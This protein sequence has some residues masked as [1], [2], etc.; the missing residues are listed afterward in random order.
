MKYLSTCFVMALALTGCSNGGSS[1]DG[2]NNSPGPNAPLSPINYAGKSD[3]ATLTPESAGAFFRYL[4]SD[5][6]TTAIAN[7][8]TLAR[9]LNSPMSTPLVLSANAIR[10]TI[11]QSLPRTKSQARAINVADSLPCPQ[12]GEMSIAGSVDEATGTG[13]VVLTYH[14][15][16]ANNEHLNG[17]MHLLFQPAAADSLWKE[18]TDVTIAGLTIVN[19]SG[20]ISVAGH[21][22]ILDNNSCASATTENILVRDDQTLDVIR[23]E[24]LVTAE[25]ICRI[26]GQ[27]SMTTYQGRIY[28]SSFGFVDVSTVPNANPNADLLLSGATLILIGA[29]G[30]SV[31]VSPATPTAMPTTA[32]WNVEFDAATN[33]PLK[34]FTLSN[35]SVVKGALY[36]LGDNDQDGLLNAWERIYGLDPNNIADA[37]QDQDGDGFSNLLEARYATSPVSATEFPATRDLRVNLQGSPKWVAPPAKETLWFDFSALDNASVFS[38][39]QDASIAFTITKS[40][41]VAWSYY[42]ECVLDEN[43]TSRLFCSSTAGYGSVEITAPDTAGEDFWVQVSLTSAILDPDLNNNVTTLKATS[44]DR[45]SDMHAYIRVASPVAVGATGQLYVY[46]NVSANSDTALD[47]IV[48][49]ALPNGVVFDGLIGRLPGQYADEKFSCTGIQV[50]SCLIGK[51]AALDS[52]NLAASVHGEIAGE[53]T[54]SVDISSAGI[55][56]HPEDNTSASTLSVGLD[57]TAPQAIVDAAAPG[58]V[59]SMPAGFYVGD[60]DFHGKSLQLDGGVNQTRLSGRIVMA[61]D[62]SMTHF[63]FATGTTVL[64]NQN[65]RIEDNIFED[66]AQ[67]TSR[68]VNLLQNGFE[69]IVVSGIAVRRNTFRGAICDPV[70]LTTHSAIVENNI[71]ADDSVT[72]CEYLVAIMSPSQ[73]QGST[74]E[75][76]VVQNNTFVRGLRGVYLYGTT[77]D[78]LL[79]DVKNNIFVDVYYGIDVWPRGAPLVTIS[80]NLYYL[81]PSLLHVGGNAESVEEI[82][83]DPQFVDSASGDYRL[84]ATSPAI[85]AGLGTNAPA[86]DFT[87]HARPVDGNNDARSRWILGLMNSYRRTKLMAR[88]PGRS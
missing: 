42:N 23:T 62:S 10:E 52:I 43:N 16:T 28:H 32:S 71:F 39:P 7:S 65:A 37:A 81:N 6:A 41:N 75:R 83:A 24:N 80:H 76:V 19:P 45:H 47:T 27:P 21:V 88:T 87:R 20:R 57:T 61:D 53:F 54:I 84:Q 11:K 49:F 30:E 22:H 3:A 40:T 78:P 82:V 60:L 26:D 18:I 70:T 79:L 1:S 46:A 73:S 64:V 33:A 12:E 34:I 14:N 69:D 48:R 74:F 8:S 67:L 51:L 63:M 35:D 58:A 68:V 66:G 44:V 72:G 36:D 5:E 2:A 86:D 15:C 13:D 50:V 56:D 29:E 55:D 17:A 4:L 25:D 31:R 38:T 85:D 9:L 77:F 59:I